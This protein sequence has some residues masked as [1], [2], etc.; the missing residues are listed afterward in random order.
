MKTSLKY[1]LY[2][3]IAVSFLAAIWFWLQNNQSREEG[4]EVAETDTKEA[5]LDAD[6][7]PLYSGA[8]W[9]RVITEEQTV[10]IVIASISTPFTEYYHEKLVVT[11]WVQDIMREA[12]GPGA[13][14]SY[15]TKDDRF[16]VI[17]F[18][19]DF[20][21]KSDDTPSECPCDVT[22]SITSGRE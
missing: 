5:R 21:V 18:E 7:Y 2:I 13:N 17:G 22:L 1:L 14:M 20:K 4:R 11:G 9:G 10:R 16:I 12:S 6:A 8:K 3:A 15:Y 19:S